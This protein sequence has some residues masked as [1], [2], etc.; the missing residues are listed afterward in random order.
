MFTRPS[1][2]PRDR[3]PLSYPQTLWCSGEQAGSFGPRFVVAK[4][5]RVTGTL[6]GAALQAA[7][8]DVVARHEQLRTV[9]VRDADPPYLQVH[10]PSR[11]PLVVRELPTEPGPDRDRLA[12][13]LLTEAES[14]SLDVHELPLLRAVLARFDDRD[15]VL[16]LVTHHTACDGWS[17]Q[18]IL[19]D[20]AACYAARTTGQPPELPPVR[21]YREY[22]VWQQEFFTGPRAVEAYA[23][24]HKQL[25]GAHIFTL[26]TDRPIPP[27]H[28]I[29][30]QAYDFRLDADLVSA[31]AGLAE[32]IRCSTFMVMLTAFN[33]LAHR[34]RGT[35]DLTINTVIHGRGQRQFENTVGPFLNF[36]ALRTCIDSGESFRDIVRR[37]RST[38]LG[39][40][41]HEVP[42]QHVEQQIPELMQPL[43]D[44][45]NCDFIFG[46]SQSPFDGDSIR[47]SEQSA[48]VYKTETVSAEIP[49]GAAWTMAVLR[50]GELIGTVQFNPEEF[51]RQTVADWVS[52]YCRLL[53]TAVH[54]PDREW[55]R[56]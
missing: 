44:P 37:T 5:V 11:V 53:A 56:L 1:P 27:T 10:P 12:E 47:L 4:A 29:P 6:D 42:I 55:K 50:T 18:L 20:L 45:R 38:C 26:P 43:H 31:A 54:E 7:L 51:D 28:S 40:Y 15:S 23:Y 34:I 16:S 49:G 52:E 21:Q 13:Q 25:R 3:F 30:Y 39:A 24:W 14:S 36:L 22:A 9:L 2:G 8:D 17:V 32:S 19:R 33:V 41:S 46:F 48:E 35:T